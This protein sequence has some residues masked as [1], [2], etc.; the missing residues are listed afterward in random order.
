MRISTKLT[1]TALLAALLLASAVGAASARNLSSSTQ[2]IRAT[3]STLEFAAITVARCQVTL[4]GSFHARTIAKVAR[5]L[6]GTITRFLVKE[7]SCVNGRVHPKNLPWHLTYESFT[8]TLPNLT[9]VVFLMSRF[10][11]EHIATGTCT[12]DY[13]AAGDNI[14]LR[15][16]REM[17]GGITS[18]ETVSNRNTALRVGAGLGFCEA[19]VR[20]TGVGAIAVLGTTTRISVTLI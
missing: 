8:G 16:N 11:F 20:L 10:L 5:T 18:L 7:E 12:A 15:G 3:W 19:L 9:N 1:L 17:G 4:E 6:I 13:G 2:N 14:S